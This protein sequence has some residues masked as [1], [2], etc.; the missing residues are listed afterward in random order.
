MNWDL[1]YTNRNH[2]QPQIP[3]PQFPKSNSLARFRFHRFFFLLSNW[4]RPGT[5]SDPIGSTA[6]ACALVHTQP[7]ALCRHGAWPIAGLAGPSFERNDREWTLHM[8][9]TGAARLEADIG[10]EK[11]SG[12]RVGGEG[13][14]RRE[15]CMGH[16]VQRVSHG[17][18]V[19]CPEPRPQG[20][21]PTEPIVPLLCSSAH[22]RCV[23]PLVSHQ[24]FSLAFTRFATE[25]LRF[26]YPRGN[27]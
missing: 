3:S 19:Q 15:K 1:Q 4:A 16:R 18:R 12:A 26:E 6:H 8:C 24:S 13:R 25:P 14:E 5:A 20:H 23:L 7:G 11:S 9:E 21:R 17:Y 27:K 10:E 22:F 2:R